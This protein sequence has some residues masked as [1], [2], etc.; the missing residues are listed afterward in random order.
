MIGHLTANRYIKMMQKTADHLGFRHNLLANNVANVNTPGYK[1]RDTADFPRLLRESLNKESFAA[2]VDDPRHI[3][4]G[5]TSFDDVQSELVEQEFTR[6]RND[7]SSVDIDLEMSEIAKN[8]M[9]YQ[10]ITKRLNS[11]F[12][13]YREIL[14]KE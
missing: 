1:R 4:F 3:Q 8:G 7:K 2:R 6:Y 14:E 12:R 13:N 10:L 9:R 5:R 11:Y